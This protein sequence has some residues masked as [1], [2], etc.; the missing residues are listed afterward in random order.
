MVANFF[1]FFNPQGLK[2]AIPK[3]CIAL[4]KGP[5]K[6]S[7]TDPTLLQLET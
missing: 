3:Y 7:Y 1:V 6:I 4:L 2:L 5:V